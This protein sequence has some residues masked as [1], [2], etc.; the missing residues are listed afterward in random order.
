MNALDIIVQA[1][2]RL[3]DAKGQRWT[4][5]RMLTIVSHCQADICVS[6]GYLRNLVYL[7]VVDGEA[8]Y[9]LPNDCIEIRRVEYDGQLL[10]LA[11]RADEKPPNLQ[12]PYIAY[13]SNLNTN[14]LEIFPV[15][16]LALSVGYV[17]GDVLE[18]E[19]DVSP[20][21]GVIVETDADNLL[22]TPAFG[23]LAGLADIENMFDEN[24]PSDG[25]GE[26]SGSSWDTVSFELPN[27]N[28]GVTTEFEFSKSDEKFGFIVD[29]KGH[30]ISGKYGITGSIALE[31]ETFKV[32]YVAVPSRLAYIGANLVIPDMWED[33]LVRYV[34]GTAL[35][36]DNDANNL[37]RGEME[38][39]KYRTKLEEIKR[40]SSDDFASSASFKNAT[41]Y[42]SI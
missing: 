12:T 7:P 30:T 1:R 8:I 38:L 27:G 35:Q 18:A 20:A 24:L 16:T 2:E 5:G 10:P 34:V 3:G 13:K 23:A 36:D 33:L 11:S 21:Y 19:G 32:Y 39:V 42:R 40:L 6:T 41:E 28:F 9:T 14:K 25:Y 17:K 4:D 31:S 29:V 15:P 37:Q 22:V 26:I